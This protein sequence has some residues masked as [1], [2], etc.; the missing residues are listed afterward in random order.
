MINRTKWGKIDYWVVDC[1][2]GS[3]DALDVITKLLGGSDGAI[4]VGIPNLPES[5]ERCIDICSFRMIKVIGCIIN[6]Y[7]AEHCGE[8][9]VCSKCGKPFM[10]FKD[11]GTIEVCKKYGVEVLG[12]IPMNP[13]YS[14]T[15]IDMNLEAIKNAIKKI[16]EVETLG[17]R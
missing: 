17:K 3:S 10:P 14:D 12:T 5:V 8:R 11:I 7:G 15:H 2:A 6:F 4:I 16:R 1:P 13:D 9:I